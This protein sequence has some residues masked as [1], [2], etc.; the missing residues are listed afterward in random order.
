MNRR[1]L[2]V[3]VLLAAIL[4]VTILLTGRPP[5][6]EAGAEGTLAL[7]RF[8]RAMDLKVTDA[9][10]PS[11]HG[12]FLLLN[13]FRDQWQAD[14]ILSWVERGGVLVLAD[15]VSKI[16]ERLSI[17]SSVGA[18]RDYASVVTRPPGCVTSETAGVTR[19]AARGADFRLNSTRP[20]AVSCFGS[21]AGS[22]LI[23]TAHGDGKA[24]VVGG[25][26]LFTNQLFRRERNALFAYQLLSTK[27]PV[28]LGAPFAS[29]S[30]LPRGTWSMVPTPAK[31]VVAQLILALIAFAFVRGR[32]L[33]RPIREEAISPIAAGELVGASADLMRQARAAS[34]AIGLVRQGALTRIARKLGIS[35]QA[36]VQTVAKL[37]GRTPSDVMRITD[38][39][40]KH[41]RQLDD[42][43]F[44]DLVRRLEE[45]TRSLEGSSR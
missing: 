15:P 33:G 42:E 7:R 13:D 16:A 10:E 20:D 12:T 8:L 19:I 22:Y 45:E 28:V 18:P 23:E 27:Q 40:T 30:K 34:Y 5:G 44:L 36:D 38:A 1:A 43:Q 11:A 25:D 14:R 26:S 39:L 6:D 3:G 35:R 24:I 17:D 2:L 21:D 37:S 9:P 31:L 32:R 41:P 4:L 29:E